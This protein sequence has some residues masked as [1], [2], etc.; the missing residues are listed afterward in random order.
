MKIGMR[1]EVERGGVNKIG[2]CG[3]GLNVFRCYGGPSYRY[4]KNRNRERCMSVFIDENI[5]C[6]PQKYL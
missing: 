5:T 2:T 3:D 4:K 6:S 1:H